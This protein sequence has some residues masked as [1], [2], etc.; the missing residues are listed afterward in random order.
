MFGCGLPSSRRWSSGVEI[1][2][3]DRHRT[4]DHGNTTADVI[5]IA[6]QHRLAERDAGGP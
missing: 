3:F 1:S 2:E 4:G 6:I 5:G